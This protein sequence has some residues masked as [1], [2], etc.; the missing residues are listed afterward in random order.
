MVIHCAE[1]IFDNENVLDTEKK[2]SREIGGLCVSLEFLFCS[3]ID[4]SKIRPHLGLEGD[5]EGPGF[6]EGLPLGDDDF[7]GMK[8]R[9]LADEVPVFDA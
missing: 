1:V 7:V 5:D 9:C 8:C 4:K 3:P 2:K 6:D